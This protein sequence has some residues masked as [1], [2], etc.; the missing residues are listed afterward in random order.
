VVISFSSELSASP[1]KVWMLLSP[2][3]GALKPLVSGFAF[4]A[5]PG[6]E[7]PPPEPDP[8][9]EPEPESPPLSFFEA[10]EPE[11]PP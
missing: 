9:S 5:R 10:P 4:S 6:P 2:P 11:S 1:P 3:G 7:G 8:S